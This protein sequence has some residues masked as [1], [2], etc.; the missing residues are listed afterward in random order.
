VYAYERRSLVHVK[1]LSGA[2]KEIRDALVYGIWKT[3]QF[4]NEQ[5]GNLFGI[6]YSGVSHAVKSAKINLSK[7]RGLQSQ[8]NRLNSLFKLDPLVH[9]IHAFAGMTSLT[10]QRVIPANAGIQQK[11]VILIA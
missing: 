5:I 10:H 9:W 4:K 1:G 7:N 3:A 11:L 2:A 6:S 8:V